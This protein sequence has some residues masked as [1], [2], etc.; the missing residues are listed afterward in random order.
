MH[1]LVDQWMHRGAHYKL[2]RWIDKVSSLL[3]LRIIKTLLLSRR[4]LVSRHDRHLRLQ[5]LHDLPHQRKGCQNADLFSAT[6]KSPVSNEEGQS[7]ST[8]F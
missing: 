2:G 6:E 4:T 3:S 8:G 1:L 7:G 5:I